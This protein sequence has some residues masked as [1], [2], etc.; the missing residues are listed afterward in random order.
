MH[1][2][3]RTL[4]AKECDAQYW[5]QIDSNFCRPAEDKLTTSEPPIV[6]LYI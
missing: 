3:L 1:T 4:K 2:K 5:S 6:D